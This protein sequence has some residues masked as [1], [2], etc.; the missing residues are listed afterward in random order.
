MHANGGLPSTSSRLSNSKI[1][2]KQEEK[3]IEEKISQKKFEK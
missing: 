1:D 3:N 2:Q